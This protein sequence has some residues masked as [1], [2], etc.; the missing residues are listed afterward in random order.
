MELDRIQS[1]ASHVAVADSIRRWI[2]LGV[3]GPGDRL[4]AERDLAERLGVGRMTIRQAVRQLAEEGLVS[5]QRGRSGGT[6]VLDDPERPLPTREISEQMMAALRENYEFRFGV[7]PMAAKLAAERADDTER[8]GIRGLAEGDANSVRAFRALDS[9]FHL[10]VANASHNSL[11]IDA[12]SR[13][14]TELFA[15]AD[16]AWERMDWSAVPAEERDFGRSHRPIAAAIAAADGKLA[17]EQMSDHLAEGLRQFEAMVKRM[18]PELT[19]AKSGDD[20][21]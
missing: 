10:A 21:S 4:P 19:G 6:F 5:T 3:L 12:V 7:E 9:R 16:P 14:R 13:S 11:I 20:I 18:A 15:W 2:A 17:G 1:P 8:W